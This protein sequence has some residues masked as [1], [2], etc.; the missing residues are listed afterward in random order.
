MGKQREALLG[1]AVGKKGVGKTYATLIEIQRYL[2][3]NPRTGAKPRKVLILDVN[4]E[5]GNIKGNGE[6]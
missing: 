4:N 2:K 6:N 5:F 1:I 3:G